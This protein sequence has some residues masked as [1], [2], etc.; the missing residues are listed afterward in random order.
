MVNKVKEKKEQYIRKTTF[1]LEYGRELENLY[2]GSH[3]DNGKTLRNR[4]E[5]ELDIC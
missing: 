1:K 5:S 4:E 3:V 2:T